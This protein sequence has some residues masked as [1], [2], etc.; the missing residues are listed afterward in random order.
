MSVVFVSLSPTRPGFMACEGC[1]PP[2]NPLRRSHT[3]LLLITA[4]NSCH[5]FI[6]HW[7]LNIMQVVL[8]PI[9]WIMN[10]RHWASSL[11]R[12]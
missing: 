5:N 2:D 1:S 3:A 4:L 10:Y 8:S 6:L 11:R 12:P 9:P 7:F